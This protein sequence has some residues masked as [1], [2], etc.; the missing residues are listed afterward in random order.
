MSVHLQRVRISV[1]TKDQAHA[2]TNS[3]VRFCFEIEDDQPHTVFEPGTNG[4]ALDHRFHDDFRRG[5]AD[6]YEIVFGSGTAG[7]AIDGTPIPAG[8]QFGSLDEAR[9]F[10]FYLQIDG[11][12]QWVFDRYMLGGFFQE[13]KPDPN[14][15]GKYELVDLGW[16]EL[17]KHHGDVAMSTDPKE[18]VDRYPVELNGSFA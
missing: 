5:E 13:L 16:L 4:V 15:P 12:D 18:G 17:A 3:T 14:H 2:A 6:S 9:R 8:L 11:S 1:H 7:T 10:P